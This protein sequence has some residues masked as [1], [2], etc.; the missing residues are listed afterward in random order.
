MFTEKV[1]VENLDFGMYVSQ[2]DRPWLESP[3][4]LQGFMIKDE[5]EIAQLREY[6]EF[7]YIDLEQSKTSNSGPDSVTPYQAQPSRNASPADPKPSIE[8]H[9]RV[10]VEKEIE[11]ARNARASL[12]GAVG[13]LMDA[14]RDGKKPQH[15]PQSRRLHAAT[16]PAG[17]GLLHVLALH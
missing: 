13:S 2:L 14:V 11:F 16:Q 1:L 6:C 7:V 17:E 3:F 15:H 10:S 8:R 5:E 12:Q 9:D 4:M